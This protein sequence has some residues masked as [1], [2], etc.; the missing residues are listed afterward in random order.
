MSEEEKIQQ[1]QIM[2][3]LDDLDKVSENPREAQVAVGV[4]DVFFV[5]GGFCPMFQPIPEGSIG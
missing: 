3:P 1:P 2:V 5:G 4:D